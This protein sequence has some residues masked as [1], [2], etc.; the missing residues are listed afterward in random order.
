MP[1]SLLATAQSFAN[2]DLRLAR[3]SISSSSY[4]SGRLEIFINAQWGT[5]CDD[6]FGYTDADVA[7][8]QLGY[9]GASSSPVTASSRSS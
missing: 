6:S 3:G 2:G 4:S 5:V 7:C 8:R 9:P 1:H